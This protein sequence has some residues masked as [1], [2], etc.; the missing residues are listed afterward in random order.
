ME[1]RTMLGSEGR[2]A[3]PD[4]ERSGDG[5]RSR[6]YAGRLRPR[7][8]VARLV[9]LWRLYATMDLLWMLRDMQTVVFWIVSDMIV[10]TVAATGTFLLAARFNGI[11]LWNLEHVV[12]LLGYALTVGGVPAVLFNY[13]LAFISRRIGRGQLDHILIQPHPIWMA[14]LTEG[15]A[16]FTAAMT[17][18]PGVAVLISATG[19]AHVA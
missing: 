2:E 7:G 1:V 3:S 14:L 15:F 6:L 5:P 10:T 18:L 19:A 11:G 17:L 4:R 13:N 16:P 9:A 8:T 12:F